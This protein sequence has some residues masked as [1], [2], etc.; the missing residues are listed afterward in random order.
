MRWL[1]LALIVLNAGLYAWN[2]GWLPRPTAA[3]GEVRPQDRQINPGALRLVP[4]PALRPSATPAASAADT[5]PPP[6]AN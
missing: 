4:E 5:P 2:A 3:G 6:A 1:V